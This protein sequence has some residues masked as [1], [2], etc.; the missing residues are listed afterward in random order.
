MVTFQPLCEN[1]SEVEG[2][3]FSEQIIR[4]RLPW[5]KRLMRVYSTNAAAPEME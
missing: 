4:R 3:L 5:L 2:R 1:E